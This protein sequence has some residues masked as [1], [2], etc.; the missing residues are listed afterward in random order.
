VQKRIEVC[1]Q[2]DLTRVLKD[3]NVPI[4]IGGDLHLETYETESPLLIVRAGNLHVV[5][6]E[7]SQP[8]VEAWG[9]SQPHVVARG[10]SQPHVVARESSQPH[11]VAW[12]SSQPH[13]VA[14][15]SSQPHVVAR[16]SSQPHVEAWGSSQPHVEARGSS[17]PHVVARE[18]SQ[19]HVVARESSQPHVVARE[20]SQPHVVAWESSQ[21]HVVAREHTQLQVRGAVIVNATKLVSVV[22]HGKTPRVRGG[23]LIRLRGLATAKHWCEHYGLEVKGGVVVVFKAVAN[24]DYKSSHG[25]AYAPGTVPIASDWDG[26]KAECGGGLHFSPSPGHA[27]GFFGSAG[28]RFLACPVRLKDIRSPREND[29]YPE[30]IKARGCCAPVWEVDRHG[31]KIEAPAK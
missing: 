2:A 19:P 4:I 20:S 18:S 7:S 12:G 22:A 30:K 17:Q 8:H 16:G 23:R 25:Q 27:E 29:A 6:W 15:G 11:V 31:N 13:V 14:R 9:S 26:G 21:P 5:A 24:T 1:T 28:V 10:S 3:G